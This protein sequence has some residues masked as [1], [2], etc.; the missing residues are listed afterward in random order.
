MLLVEGEHEYL[1]DHNVDGK[2]MLPVSSHPLEVA[3]IADCGGG[4]LL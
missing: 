4:H 1:C 3:G 2:V